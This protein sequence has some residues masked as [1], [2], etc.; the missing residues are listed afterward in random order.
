VA[1][2][3]LELE[4][5]AVVRDGSLSHDDVISLASAIGEPVSHCYAASV[6]ADVRINETHADKLVFCVGACQRWGA[7]DCIDHSVKRLAERAAVGHPRFAIGVRQCLDRCD[8]APVC[9]VLTSKGKQLIT[10]ADPS[11]LDAVLDEL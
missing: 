5:A 9:E 7:L 1:K 6:L 11:R 10:E 2:L 8:Q 4:D 3:A